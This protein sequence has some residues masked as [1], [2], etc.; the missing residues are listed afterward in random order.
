[1]AT[2]CRVVPRPYLSTRPAHG[3]DQPSLSGTAERFTRKWITKFLHTPPPLPVTR[4]LD[5]NT[6]QGP[7][8][9]A[10]TPAH[11]VQV[12]D[13]PASVS[14]GSPPFTLLL[15][16]SFIPD[17]R[18]RFHQVASAFC[19][20]SSVLLL[21]RLHLAF[22]T[23]PLSFFASPFAHPSSLHSGKSTHPHF[24]FSLRAPSHRPA[25]RIA[26]PLTRRSMARASAFGLSPLHTSPDSD[27]FTL[28]R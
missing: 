3:P 18:R 15:T 26:R 20:P 11:S 28:L 25:N 16:S 8:D 21:S 10:G 5:P 7:L 27:S 12:Q 1:M 9:P 19:S 22:S 17:L 2:S 24:A 6:T 23:L 13:R 4:N 14:L